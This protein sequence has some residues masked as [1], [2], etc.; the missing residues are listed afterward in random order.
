MRRKDREITDIN[1]ILAIIKKCDTCRIALFDKK[2]PYIVPLNFGCNYDNTNLELYFHCAKEGLKLEL[3]KNNNHAAFEM[4]CS[5]KLVTG[6]SAC[7]YSMKFE[8]VCGQGIIQAL[9]AEEK[10]EALIFLMKQY[11]DADSFQ[12]QE[13]VLEK[14]TV[15]K[16]KIESITGKR[17]IK[18]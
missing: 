16:L 8:S 13:R 18:N 17:L 5:H 4:D 14:V 3:I 9:N 11:S 1:D 15:L 2:Y 7:H 12:F 10:K 6:E